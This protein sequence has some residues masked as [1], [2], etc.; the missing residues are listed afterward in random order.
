[1]AGRKKTRSWGGQRS[2]A[3]RKPGSG[4]PKE[5]IRRNRLMISLTDDELTSLRRMAEQRG[6]PT[7]TLAYQIVARVLR[8]KR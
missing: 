8:P 7:G 3:G 2:G 4:R 6:L 5:H 1:M